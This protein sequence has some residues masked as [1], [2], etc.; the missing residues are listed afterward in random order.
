VDITSYSKATSEIETRIKY[1]NGI[2]EEGYQ[3]NWLQHN[4]DKW[5][6]KESGKRTGGHNTSRSHEEELKRQ[7][8]PRRFRN[9]H[10]LNLVLHISC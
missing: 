2:S 1:K 10:V 7:I 8:A 4:E 6:T 3:T 5:N 9:R